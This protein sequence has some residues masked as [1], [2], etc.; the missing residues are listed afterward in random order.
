MPPIDRIN[1]QAPTSL[2]SPSLPQACHCCI[3]LTHVFVCGRP[4]ASTNTAQPP[5]TQP[6]TSPS[7]CTPSPRRGPPPVTPARHGKETAGGLHTPAARTSRAGSM[8][9]RFTGGHH[10]GRSRRTGAGRRRG[11]QPCRRGRRRGRSH[12]RGGRSGSPRG[13]PRS[14]WGRARGGR[15]ARGCAPG[16]CGE[17]PGGRMARGVSRGVKRRQGNSR[18]AG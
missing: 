9:G 14:A 2:S 16:A 3:S 8:Q 15:G 18:S 4:S 1:R 13:H 12:P 17:D 10:R 5:P 7:Q 11:H 6:C